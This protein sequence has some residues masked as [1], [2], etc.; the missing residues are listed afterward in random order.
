[1]RHATLTWMD[2]GAELLV[3]RGEIGKELAV[4]L[5]AEAQRRVANNAFFGYIAYTSMVGRK[6]AIGGAS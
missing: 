5:K 1:M 2:R 6:I 4:A 3:A